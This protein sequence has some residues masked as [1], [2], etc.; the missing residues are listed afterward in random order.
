MCL[1]VPGRI[2]EITGDDPVVRM[3]RVDFSGVQKEVSLAYV[4]EAVI[5]DFVIVHV[6]FALQTV[7]EEEARRTLELIQQ[8]GEA[9]MNEDETT[10]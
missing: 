8:M 7:D 5:G 10:P 4:P 6:G 9:G 1:A 3:A 2:V